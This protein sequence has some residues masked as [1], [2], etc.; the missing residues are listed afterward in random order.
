MADKSYVFDVN[1]AEQPVDRGDNHFREA[2]RIGGDPE[3]RYWNPQSQPLE[4]RPDRLQDVA[5][6]LTRLE[7]ELEEIREFLKNCRRA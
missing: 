5:A 3:S 6:R 1:P 4:N 7:K 2:V